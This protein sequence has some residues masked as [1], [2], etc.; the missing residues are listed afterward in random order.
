MSVRSMHFRTM[1][2]GL[3]EIIY[4]FLQIEFGVKWFKRYFRDSVLWSYDQNIEM[5]PNFKFAT[6]LKMKLQE[7][8]QCAFIN[9]GDVECECKICQIRDGIEEFKENLEDIYGDGVKVDLHIPFVW[10]VMN[11]P[12][13]HWMCHHPQRTR[14]WINECVPGEL[15]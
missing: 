15:L 10:E 4:V 3:Y 5:N 2:H 11:T 1:I 12:L 6:I 13:F 7:G 14:E 8:V 9:D